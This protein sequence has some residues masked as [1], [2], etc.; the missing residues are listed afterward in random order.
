MQLPLGSRDE[1]K[2]DV[3]PIAS[4]IRN[5]ALEQRLCRQMAYIIR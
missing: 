3:K 5:E 1:A 2:R 4:D